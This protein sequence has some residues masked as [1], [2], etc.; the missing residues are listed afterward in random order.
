[1]RVYK[2]KNPGSILLLVLGLMM[3]ATSLVTVFLKSVVSD[4]MYN[5]QLKDPIDLKVAAYSYLDLTIGTLVQ[6]RKEWGG[7]LLFTKEWLN[8]STETTNAT[9]DDKDDSNGHGSNFANNETNAQTNQDML[10]DC[11]LKKLAQRAG[12]KE[13]D[14]SGNKLIAK[15]V[16]EVEIILEDETGKLPLCSEFYNAIPQDLRGI[17][18]NVICSCVFGGKSWILKNVNKIDFDNDKITN[19]NNAIKDI[20]TLT[21]NPPKAKNGIAS[22]R[23]FA[24]LLQEKLPHCEFF[25][26]NGNETDYFLILQEYFTVIPGLEKNYSKFKVNI[27]TANEELRSKLVE[28]KGKSNFKTNKTWYTETNVENSDSNDSNEGSSKTILKMARGK[29][30]PYTEYRNILKSKGLNVDELTY[31]NFINFSAECMKIAVKISGEVN[32]STPNSKNEF[33]VVALVGT[34][35]NGKGRFNTFDILSIEEV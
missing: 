10:S 33:T 35:T 34:L 1:M 30:S 29:Q 25:D 20:F 26:E 11:F 3:L 18:G 27:L 6:L 16:P 17:Y 12:L 13:K 9:E 22:V 19:I 24:K 4:V 15:A 28:S 5:S 23:H 2:S 7:G 32:R 31:K 14:I 8:G 21:G